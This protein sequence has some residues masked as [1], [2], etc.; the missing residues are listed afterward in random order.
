[1]GLT[2]L[3]I[4][5]RAYVRTVDPGSAAERAGIQP[6][7]CVQLACVVGGTKFDN[8]QMMSSPNKASRMDNMDNENET[9][10]LD[11]KARQYVLDC[12]RRGMAVHCHQRE[13]EEIQ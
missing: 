8:I 10:R 9:D 7:D 12:E 2:F 11:S 3:E 1:L 5:D 13:E 4:N 6:E